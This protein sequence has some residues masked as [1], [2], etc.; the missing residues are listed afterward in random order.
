MPRNACKAGDAAH[1]ES[2][3]AI[4]LL[5]QVFDDP[6]F[7]IIR[8][9]VD[10]RW[11]YQEVIESRVDGF[12]PLYGAVFVG[13]H[14][15]VDRWI[16]H[17]HES[18]RPFNEGD[19]LVPE[20]LFCVHDYLHAWA[21]QWIDRLQ[22]GLGFGRSPITRRNFE[23]MVFCHI[24]SEAVATV[25][26]DYWYLA[27]VDLNRV[28]PIGTVQRGLTASY[29]EELIEEYRRFNPTLNVQ[30]PSFLGQLTRFY[31]DGVFRGF[32]I[33]DL[34]HSPAIQAWLTH[35]LTYGRLQRRYCREW[36]AYLSAEDIQLSPEQLDGAIDDTAGWKKPLVA[37]LG[38]QLWSKVKRNEMC[39]PGA[40]LDPKEVWKAPQRRSPDFRF[41]NL[42]RCD[43]V[44]K[45]SAKALSEDAF[46]FLMRQYVA[47]FDRGAFPAEA[48]GVFSLIR[49]ERDFAIG[50]RLLRGIKRLPVA[51][52]EPRDL[53]LYN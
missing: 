36:F 13:T 46:D 27:T 51:R 26:L 22:P 43:P 6:C 1:P 30:H 15:R 16:A 48:L 14:S 19:E 8:R 37:A 23:D 41:L 18:A 4:P 32:D 9:G 10:S 44:S 24:L 20:A 29:R 11:K 3:L 47:R 42:N 25:G 40:H 21:Y 2:L 31:C 17:R 33:R 50:E 38:E 39:S 7:A 5:A 53:F 49:Q 45:N 52:E 34:Q 12:N 35:E 28:V